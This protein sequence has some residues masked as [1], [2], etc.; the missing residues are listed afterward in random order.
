MP[1]SDYSAVP[2]GVETKEVI[3]S[4]M[5]SLVAWAVMPSPIQRHVSV[6]DLE[7]AHNMLYQSIVNKV[8]EDSTQLNLKLGQCQD[9]VSNK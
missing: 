9:N 2:S 3:E 4:I 7:R 6:A 1:C 8:A 5:K